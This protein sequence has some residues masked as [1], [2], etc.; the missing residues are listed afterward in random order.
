MAI[1]ERDVEVVSETGELARATRCRVKD[2]AIDG[3]A[4]T[5]IDDARDEVSLPLTVDGTVQRRSITRTISRDNGEV[6]FMVR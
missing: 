6:V 1:V 5:V 4:A 2:D 3:I